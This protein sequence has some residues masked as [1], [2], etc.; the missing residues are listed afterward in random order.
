VLLSVS[1]SAEQTV[2]GTLVHDNTTRNCGLRLPKNLTTTESIPLVFD[3]HG[4]SSNATE[5]ELYSNMNALG[6]AERFAVCYPN[7]IQNAWNAG[8]N[9]GSSADDVGFV[10]ALIDTLVQKY[11]FN[12]NR[13][14]AC[15][16]SNGGYLSYYLGC[17]LPH[18]V[19]AVASVTGSMIPAVIQ[20]CQPGR[21]MPILEFHGTEDNVVPYGGA[22]GLASPVDSV[23]AFWVRNNE[24]PTGP[25]LTQLP[26]TNP[27]DESTVEK[28]AYT[29]CAE[30]RDV[31]LYKIIGGGHTWPGA[32]LNIGS[33]NKDI[34]ANVE[35]WNF[36][37]KYS[38]PS[39]SSAEDKN[40]DRLTFFPNPASDILYW[41]GVARV[42]TIQ[43]SD[44]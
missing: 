12:K 41:K 4:Y 16:M 17:R 30:A 32:L 34:N 21:S 8:W 24:C 28:Y 10:S 6:D 37:K 2:T 29:G 33:T 40:I 38:L 31:I 36:F 14:Y 43:I 23:I 9:F 13:I 39:S 5:Q 20:N 19:A 26:D 1:L 35:I 44:I 22:E 25:L 15:G 18:K 11:N 27:N 42:N 3:F 7:G